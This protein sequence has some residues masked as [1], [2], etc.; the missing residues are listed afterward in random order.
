MIIS[1]LIDEDGVVL[2]R[3]TLL[4]ELS[5]AKEQYEGEL[6]ISSV[7]SNKDYGIGEMIEFEECC[8]I[9]GYD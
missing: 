2:F 6:G 1:Y 3:T 5:R 9:S 4:D 8:Y 7:V